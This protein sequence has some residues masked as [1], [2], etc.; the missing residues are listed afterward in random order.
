M[1]MRV[2]CIFI[3]LVASLQTAAQHY[4][5]VHGSPYAG[6]LGVGNNPAAIVH[7]PHA[8]DLTILGFQEKHTTNAVTV[9][10]YSLLSS[11]GQSEYLFNAGNYARFA[12]VNF[13]L[14]MLN[15][16]FAINRQQAIA[17]GINIRGYGN[18][19]T[20]PYHF[21]DTVESSR[22]F[23]SL[24]NS[25]V[26]LRGD[27]TGS[28]WLELFGTYAQ[29]M[30]DGTFDRLNA[31]VTLKISRA[32]AGAHVALS[33]AHAA[34]IG[35]GAGQYYEYTS[36]SGVYGYSANFDQWQDNKNSSQNIKDFISA[37]SY[38]FSVDFGA[39]YLIKSG[40]ITAWDED[41]YYDYKWK[42]G[43]ALLDLGFN[44]FQY[45]RHSRT[46][47]G[48]RPN[49]ADTLFD[50]KW[51]GVED[52]ASFN[53][54]LA[55]IVNN[56]QPLQGRFTVINPT[57]L[58]INADRHLSGDFY[59]NADLT[60]NLS[61]LTGHPY[62]VTEAN[63]LTIIP[64]WETRMLGFFLPVLVNIEGKWWIG[65]AFKAGPLLLGVHN[66]GNVFSKNKMQNGGGYLAL[67][68]R[69]GRQAARDRHLKQYECPE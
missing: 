6:S 59:V 18:I 41:D 7:N 63:L 13:N 25:T 15:G 61:S 67:V 65:G 29:T 16:R 1:T 2:P 57:R 50:E 45:G 4:S 30:W 44:R 37:G 49:M 39:E 32:L 53:D 46:V 19:K 54:S 48:V 24:G 43:V 40:A 62:R 34:R 21:V 9:Y 26:R 20:G 14:N 8:W 51:E 33:N 27:F 52:F 38:G 10:N 58:V 55:T 5:A 17:F 36:G 28:S 60:I 69:P 56:M 23:F 22:E 47:S 64:R 12:H 66:W 31:G 11:P 68:I 42:I 35:H 3:L